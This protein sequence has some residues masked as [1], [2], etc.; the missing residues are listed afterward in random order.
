L[1]LY[2]KT[3]RATASK[4]KI[5]QKP[6]AINYVGSKNNGRGLA[7]TPT[8]TEARRTTPAA[9]RRASRTRTARTRRAHT[10]RRRPLRSRV[11]AC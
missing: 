3:T 4:R 5:K 11:M 8:Q 6:I 7:R 2:P 9:T 10:R 1:K